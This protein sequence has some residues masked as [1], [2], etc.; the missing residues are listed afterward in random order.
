MIDSK[1]KVGAQREERYIATKVLALT[2]EPIIDCILK[3]VS[4][5]GACISVAEFPEVVPD[6]FRLAIDKVQPKCRV[7]WRSGN[8]IGIEFYDTRAV[9]SR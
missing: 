8:D 2:G 3:N 6:Y 1:R 5:H 9:A 7:K 4:E